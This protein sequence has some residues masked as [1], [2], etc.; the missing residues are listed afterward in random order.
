MKYKLRAW[1]IGIVREAIRIERASIQPI[2]STAP[3]PPFAVKQVEAEAR[4][5]V[6]SIHVE[7]SFEQMQTE[8]LKE[9]EKHYDPR[10]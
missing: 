5:T 8:A 1:L 4:K 6:E 10:P 3:K 2:R 7:L 9:Q